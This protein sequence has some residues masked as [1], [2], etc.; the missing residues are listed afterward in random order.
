MTKIKALNSNWLHRNRAVRSRVVLTS[1]W[2]CGVS[3]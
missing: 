2:L 1:R 3:L